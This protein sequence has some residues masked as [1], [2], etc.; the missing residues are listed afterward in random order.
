M[1]K[2][3]GQILLGSIVALIIIY[4]VED[5]GHIFFP[6]PKNFDSMN[7]E[8]MAK[9]IRRVPIEA[10]SFP[11]ISYTIGS[12][13]GGIVAN[14]LSKKM[15]ISLL[16]GFVITFITF[17]MLLYIP[18]PIWFNVVALL[19]PLPASYFGGSLGKKINLQRINKQSNI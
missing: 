13:A 7:H 3:I 15:K 19:L 4:F 1:F 16:V 11:L 18:H 14:L 9:Y 10:L 17:L 2:H 6:L 5:F 8:H 12:F